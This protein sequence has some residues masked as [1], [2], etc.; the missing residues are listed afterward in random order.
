MTRA[1]GSRRMLTLRYRKPPRPPEGPK[2]GTGTPTHLPGRAG[3]G[4]PGGGHPG[5]QRGSHRKSSSGRTRTAD[6]VQTGRATRAANVYD[7]VD[8]DVGKAIPYGVH[9]LSANTRLVIAYRPRRRLVR[10]GRDHSLV[11][12]G[13]P[14][15]PPQSRP[16]A[17]RRRRRF[18]R[19]PDPTMEDRVR[20]TGRASGLQ[21]TPAH[22]PPGTSK[23]KKIEHRLLAHFDELARAAPRLGANVGGGDRNASDPEV[24]SPFVSARFPLRQAE[25]G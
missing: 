23:R 19:V 4:A 17:H 25:N 14:V 3:R 22:L 24:I 6:G 16:A 11:A 13:R 5:D 12:G 18:H 1:N 9:D 20:G 21:V 7:F 15:D 2:H 10:R 8:T